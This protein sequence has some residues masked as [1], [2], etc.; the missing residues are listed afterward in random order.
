MAQPRPTETAPR[1]TGVQWLICVIAA[2]GFAFDTYELLVLPL[3][4]RPALMEMAK[5]KPGTPEFN[6]WV[7]L[8]FYIPAVAGG[9]FGLLGGYLTDRL[10]RRRVL[11]WSILIYAVSAMGAGFATSVTQLLILRC[12]T[13]IG[14]CVEFVAA[15]A[16]LGELFPHLT[17][18]EKGAGLHTGVLF[19]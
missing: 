6:L 11:V 2:L 5:I 8:L 12:T 15:V 18:R 17:Q 1:L 3:I 14:V 10:G 19:H 16:W 9:I 7:G 13:F 4:V